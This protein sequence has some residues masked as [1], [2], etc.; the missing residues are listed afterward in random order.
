MFV[1]GFKQVTETRGGFRRL[2]EHHLGDPL[3]LQNGCQLG[4]RSQNIRPRIGKILLLGQ[5]S[6]GPKT[7]LPLG[8]QPIAH[9]GGPARTANLD[10]AFFSPAAEKKGS[11]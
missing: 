3:L 7:V 4:R 1:N 11:G 5:N 6:N 2:Q 9:G 8:K 10:Q